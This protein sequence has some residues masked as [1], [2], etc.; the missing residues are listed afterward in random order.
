MS[1]NL[2]LDTSFKNN[3]WKFINCEYKNGY[4]YSTESIFGIEQELILPDPTK[5]Y[6]RCK[7]KIENIDIKEVK[8]GIQINDILYIDKKTPKLQKEQL[9][10]VIDDVKQEKIKLHI[11]FESTIKTN[12]VEIKEPLLVNLNLLHKS[13]SLKFILNNSLKYREGYHYKNIYNTLEIKP[14]SQDF[15]N[16]PLEKAK[17]GSILKTKEKINIK[18][19]AKF[20]RGEYYLIKLDYK[21]INELGNIQFKYGS[22]ASMQFGKEQIYIIIRAEDKNDL[23]LIIEPNDILDYQINLKHIMIININKMKLLKSDVPYLP[24]I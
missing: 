4:L 20:N 8:I 23:E 24:F 13:T 18:I 10:S 7:Y 6:F 16:Y 17:T 1:Y 15:I 9:I 22:I 19:N 14:E 5:L 11:I 21:E 2:L 3:N 12:I